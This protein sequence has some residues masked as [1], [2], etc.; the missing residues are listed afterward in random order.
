MNEY[1]VEE[2]QEHIDAA[3][4]PNLARGAWVLGNL[5]EWTNRNSDGWPYWRKPGKSA[6]RL[7]A[8]LHEQDY[9]IRFGHDRQGN[10]LR[11][12]TTSELTRAC[13]PIKSFLTKY[14][15]VNGSPDAQAEV[16]AA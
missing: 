9:A 5:V 6:E 2:M 11:D 10:P 8:M 12:V 7:M 14:G 4:F 1:D 3:E 16:F 15:A 13:A